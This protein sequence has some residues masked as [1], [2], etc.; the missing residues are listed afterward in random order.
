M[1]FEEIIPI[2]LC[3]FSPPDTH[4]PV[5]NPQHWLHL[6]HVF[7]RFCDSRHG[8]PP[9]QQLRHEQSG[10]A[11]VRPHSTNPRTRNFTDTA[12]TG[13]LPVQHD[14]AATDALTLFPH[15]WA[16]E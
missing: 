12:L 5:P 7:Q 3:V 9:Y 8:Q 2:S 16:Q 11:I 6:G 13:A 4:M 10:R 15:P 14:L 1:P